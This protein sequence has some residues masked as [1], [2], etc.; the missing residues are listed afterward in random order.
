LRISNKEPA[1]YLQ[2]C[3]AKQPG[4]VESH[5]IPMDGE[6]WRPENYHEFLAARRELLAQAANDF[7]DSLLAGTVPEQEVTVEVLEGEPVPVPGGIAT[8]E[9]ERLLQ[10]CN[11]WVTQQGLPEGECPYELADPESGE[12]IAILDLAWPDGLQEG[13]SQPVALLID[14]G[15]ETEEAANRA[16]YRYFSDAGTFRSYVEAEILIL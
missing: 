15:R 3:V 11:E 7:L 8:D 4:A 9:E 1:E 5:W 10:E 2:E 14:E 16:G 13:L 12:P 6:L